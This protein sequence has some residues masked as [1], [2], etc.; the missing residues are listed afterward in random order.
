MRDARDENASA[1]VPLA[2]KSSIAGKSMTR[3]KP[4][5]T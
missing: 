3:N 4:R 2:G 1:A 5:R